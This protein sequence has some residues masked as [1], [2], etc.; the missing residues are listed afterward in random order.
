V[1]Q[2]VTPPSPG[3]QVKV[4]LHEAALAA[5]E[6]NLLGKDSFKKL[7]EMLRQYPNYGTRMPTGLRYFTFDDREIIT[8]RTWDNELQILAIRPTR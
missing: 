7:I 3:F 5:D 4:S 8:R 2:L 6:N 1:E